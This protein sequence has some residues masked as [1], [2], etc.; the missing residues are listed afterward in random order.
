MT[1]F[2]AAGGVSS[3]V[4]GAV[5]GFLLTVIFFLGVPL[6][7][8]RLTAS[9]GANRVFSRIVVR[10]L[11]EKFMKRVG[12]PGSF[13]SEY[14][15]VGTP[16]LPNNLV[17]RLIQV[18][19]V[20]FLIASDATLLLKP[21]SPMTEVNYFFAF[22]FVSLSGVAPFIVL[23]W[24]YEDAGLRRYDANDNTVSKVGTWLEAFFVGTGVAT[25]FLKFAL[26]L[27]GGTIEAVGAVTALFLTLVPPCLI[28]TVIFHREVQAKY[29]R[30][31][32]S[33]ESVKTL[34]KMESALG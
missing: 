7:C 32:L 18:I 12:V 11:H 3:G 10:K 20:V 26:S 6:G 16:R 21:P 15:L 17:W 34:R 2:T 5:G 25:S 27:G 8:W 9:R 29:V 23:L 19:S 22:G 1:L 24:V 30:K 4:I 14:V 13:Q 33:S 28:V 31:F